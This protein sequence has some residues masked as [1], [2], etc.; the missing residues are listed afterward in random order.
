MASCC[1]FS[2]TAEQLSSAFLAFGLSPE[3]PV[4]PEVMASILTRQV[5]DSVSLSRSALALHKT[6]SRL[7]FNSLKTSELVRRWAAPHVP[8]PTSPMVSD[9]ALG[10]WRELHGEELEPA[11]AGGAIALLSANWLIAL[12]ARGGTLLPRQ[13]IPEDAFLTLDQLKNLTRRRKGPMSV[14]PIVVVSHEWASAKHPDPDRHML[15][16]VASALRPLIT[17]R[18]NHGIFI[19]FCSI[20]QNCRGR[21][22][23]AASTRVI[24]E[25]GGTFGH[26]G[27]SGTLLASDLL[28]DTSRMLESEEQLLKQACIHLPTLLSHPD[29]M[30]FVFRHTETRSHLSKDQDLASI[31]TTSNTSE[32]SMWLEHDPFTLEC[33]LCTIARPPQRSLDLSERTEDNGEAYASSLTFRP[34]SRCM[35]PL[36]PD[37][38]ESSL[39]G[40]SSSPSGKVKGPTLARMYRQVYASRFSRLTELVYYRVLWGD[41]EIEMLSKVLKSGG[42]PKLQRLQLS[43]N[44]ITDVGTIALANGLACTP[45]LRQLNLFSNCIGDH[46]ASAIANA[47]SSLPALEL[48]HLGRNKLSD[49]AGVSIARRLVEAVSLT[50]LLLFENEMSKEG[51]SA[52][53]LAWGQRG[54]SLVLWA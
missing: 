40:P 50:Q 20:H 51:E 22:G 52:V 24:S 12:A 41:Y 14:L 25:N 32:D 9:I 39:R 7:P 19:D 5:G 10:R 2:P 17:Q 35:A 30:H 53:R 44:R 6:R 43:E 3:D 8:R 42:V 31:R 15:H 46:G 13:A 1:G 36:L 49:D 21:D 48:L 23:V 28:A 11:L 29:T 34:N 37:A 45:N 38:F 18:G 16:R 47:F 4:S 26:Y 27:S 33:L 54:G